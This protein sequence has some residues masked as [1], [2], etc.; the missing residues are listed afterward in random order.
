M[1]KNVVEIVIKAVNQA[2]KG[3][4]EPIKDIESL[5]GA[6]SKVGPVFATAAAAS[7]A[8][9]AYMVKQSIDA[10]DQMHQMAQRTGISVEALS[11]LK[12]AA[13]QSDTSIESLQKGIK[14]LSEKMVEAAQ[15]NEKS[16]ELFKSLGVEVKNADGSMRSADAVFLDVAKSFEGMGDGAL[17]A[18]RANEL[19]GKAG[20]ELIPM[21]NEGKDGIA[22]MQ[23]EARAL[24]AEIDS[25]TAAAAANLNDNIDKVTTAGSGLINAFTAGLAPALSDISDNMVDAAKQGGGFRDVLKYTGEIT[26]RVA[27]QFIALGDTVWTTFTMLVKVATGL[28]GALTQAVQGNFAEAKAFIT[29]ANKDIAKDWED[30]GKKWADAFDPTP[31]KIAADA[32]KKAAE[33]TKVANVKAS[34]DAK[35]AEEKRVADLKKLLS[36]ID[37]DNRRS[38]MSKIELIQQEQASKLAQLRELKA[39][40]SEYERA[41]VH[42]AQN[43]AIEIRKVLEEEQ[44]NFDRI[45]QEQLAKEED[46]NNARLGT[47]QRIADIKREMQTSSLTGLEAEEAAIDDAFAARMQAINTLD[48]KQVSSEERS[49]L[50]AEATMERDRRIHEARVNFLNEIFGL[51][52]ALADSMMAFIDTLSAKETEREAKL[53]T[54]KVENRKAIAALEEQIMLEDM[55]SEER[56]AYQKEKNQQK[57]AALKE[58]E[59]KLDLVHYSRTEEAFEKA[60]ITFREGVKTALIQ[61]GISAA[62]NAITA[63]ILGKLVANAWAPAAA[64]AAVATV[65]GAAVAGSAGIVTTFGVAQGIASKAHSGLDFVPTEG[66]YVLQRGERVVPPKQGEDL[67]RFLEKEKRGEGGTNGQIVVQVYLNDEALV[68]AMGRASADGRLVIDARSVKS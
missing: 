45:V 56:S 8:A 39:N 52:Q 62:A 61:A 48:E 31:A 40:E 65:G 6:M 54:D 18:T 59:R 25:N 37:R 41:R 63:I 19:F 60:W 2:K 44:A 26:G 34:D 20:M 24:G 29:A 58:R 50:S 16:V 49:A 46:A 36:E 1:A 11:T 17:K 21:L 23:A 14:G 68:K 55:S 27:K 47:A 4:Q 51:E 12:Y 66:T 33:D 9:L 22:G 57:L 10:A 13:E 38:T 5:K 53:R 43:A 28:F 3:L 32:G 35:K 30:V 15:G 64:L 7:A 67:R 42:L